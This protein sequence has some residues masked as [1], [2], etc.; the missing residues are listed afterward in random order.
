MITKKQ[1]N[2]IRMLENVMPEKDVVV[3]LKDNDDE[4]RWYL[5]QSYWGY[6]RMCE[7]VKWIDK[8]IGFW[9]SLGEDCIDIEGV[10]LEMGVV[11]NQK[12]VAR[13]RNKIPWVAWTWVSSLRGLTQWFIEKCSEHIE[14]DCLKIQDTT[15]TESFMRKHKDKLFWNDIALTQEMSDE[16]MEEFEDR[17]DVGL[18]FKNPKIPG[19]RINNLIFKH[20][21]R[22]GKRK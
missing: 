9:L 18:L 10:L 21:G 2:Y 16:F 20:N 14:W 17:L 3:A 12:S 15:L 4:L 5:R 1:K 22:F 13:Y 11:K 7:L 19:Q 6:Q 8:D